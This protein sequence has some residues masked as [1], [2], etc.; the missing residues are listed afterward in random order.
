MAKRRSTGGGP[1]KGGFGGGYG[2]GGVSTFITLSDCP[3]AYTGAGGYVVVVNAGATGLEFKAVGT[4][5]DHL[6]IV[7]GTDAI[8]NNL[9]GKITT[10]GGLNTTVI[11]GFGGEKFLE[12]GLLLDN[13]TL[14]FTGG[15]GSPMYVFATKT[16][17][18]PVISV[19][20]NTAA[21]PVAPTDGD[22]YIA[23]VT[24]HLWTVNRIYEWYAA[25]PSWLETIPV[26]G[27]VVMNKA[28]LL[29]SNY[30]GASWATI[31]ATA[32]AHDLAGALHNADTITNLNTKLSDGDVISTKA[33]EIN[34]LTPKTPAVAADLIM[35]EDSAAAFAKKKITVSDLPAAA[36]A[37][38]ASTHEPG[39]SDPVFQVFFEA[40]IKLFDNSSALPAT[41]VAGDRYIA[42]ATALGW[43]V[44]RIYEWN[45]ASWD[46]TVP[47]TNSS[48]LVKSNGL[49]ALVG[50]AVYT[51]SGAAWVFSKYAGNVLVHTSLDNNGSGALMDKV[52]GGPGAYVHNDVSYSKMVIESRPDNVTLENSGTGSTDTLRVKDLGITDAKVA[53]ANK[54]GTAAT[55]SM[56]TLGAGAQQAAG[57][58]DSRFVNEALEIFDNSTALPLYPVT[59][60]TYIALSSANGWTANYIYKW[61]G[62]SW[63]G[64]TP[65]AGNI[66]V[67]K[68]SC[69]D[70]KAPVNSF[71]DPVYGTPD[72]HG[73]V[74]NGTRYI[75]AGSFGGWTANN[76]YQWNAG[77]AAW[78]ETVVVAGMSTAVNFANGTLFAD[79]VISIFDN[80]GGLPA[81]PSVGDRYIALYTANGWTKDNIY[82]WSGSLWNA[83]AAT[84]E[85]FLIL[86]TSMNTIVYSGTAWI[87]TGQTVIYEFDGSFWVTTGRNDIFEYNGSAWAI[88][89]SPV[90]YGTGAAPAVAGKPDGSLF[91]KYI[92]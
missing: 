45:G 37:A 77:G 8:P 88:P 6:I 17:Y 20:D 62:A 33:G 87:T 55:P 21:L 86:E 71:F 13:P 42:G 39:G 50:G 78:V 24:A 61:N 74:A 34:A 49:P 79:P 2:S 15:G 32:S 9:A 30:T 41:P 69:V 81:G 16:W 64:V 28:T 56:R 70:V 19:F 3:A 43:T 27:D 90:F 38:H 36:P 52:E 66:A 23:K 47:V 10:S 92:P 35:I 46:E 54:D 57:G 75:A 84:S 18:Y 48:V 82:Q 76:I 65:S 85:L 83:T 31:T 68:H 89:Y 60:D 5:D 22:R 67:V 63:T 58:M 51:W 1:L 29:M 59:G 7:D 14:R 25:G 44:N 11:A 91:F 72:T 12:I 80:M 53:T 4:V 26:T 73:T 40:V